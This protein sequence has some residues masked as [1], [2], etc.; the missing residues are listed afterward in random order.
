MFSHMGPDARIK[1]GCSK[2]GALPV[3]TTN[4]LSGCMLPMDTQP[5]LQSSAHV[6]PCAR[7]QGVKRRPLGMHSSKA[8]TFMQPCTGLLSS[9]DQPR[10]AAVVCSAHDFFFGTPGPLMPAS[11]DDGRS[12]AY[13]NMLPVCGTQLSVCKQARTSTSQALSVRTKD[14]AMPVAA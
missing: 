4:R 11:Q 9:P 6:Q 1:V 13:T 7:C 2:I 3:S 8:I 14:T 5:T 12:S 10:L